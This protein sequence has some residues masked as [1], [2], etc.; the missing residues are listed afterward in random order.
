MK[1]FIT[2]CRQT[3]HRPIGFRSLRADSYSCPISKC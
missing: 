3:P 2:V 1:Q